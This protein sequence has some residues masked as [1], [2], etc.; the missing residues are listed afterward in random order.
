MRKRTRTPKWA[1]VL[2]M[3]YGIF[4]VGC[5]Q[6]GPLHLPEPAEKNAP[7]ESNL[8]VYRTDS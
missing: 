7:A 3:L 4:L 8:S 6:K 2:V 1:V 5:G